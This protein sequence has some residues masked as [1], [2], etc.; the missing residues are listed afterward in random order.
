[1]N[2]SDATRRGR[3]LGLDP[4]SRRIGVA[5]CDADR[6]VASPIATIVRTKD[7]PADLRKLAELARDHEV[8]E[9]VVGLP[10]SLDGTEQAAATAARELGEALAEALDLPL[11]Y[12]DERFTTVTADRLLAEAGHDS[13]SRRKV[14]DQVAAS[15]MLQSWLDAARAQERSA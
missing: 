15:V 6:T 3:A 4:G 11:S 13:R 8:V 10:L 5:V 1:V 2:P 12:H 7:L 14:V 9:L